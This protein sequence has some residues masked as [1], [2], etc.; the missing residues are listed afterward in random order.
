MVKASRISSW[1]SHELVSEAGE[2]LGARD[3]AAPSQQPDPPLVFEEVHMKFLSVQEENWGDVSAP[4]VPMVPV[5]LLLQQRRSV[6]MR[7]H[8][9]DTNIPGLQITGG[10]EH[11]NMVDWVTH[12]Y[13][14][15]LLR[16]G[17]LQNTWYKMIFL[18]LTFWITADTCFHFCLWWAVSLHVCAWQMYRAKQFG[19][20]AW[21]YS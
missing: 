11:H 10:C 7:A 5:Q 19:Y 21:R 18:L 9:A 20:C 15:W 1:R 2:C 17:G 14:G 8:P 16:Y 13:V 12:I 3:T 6:E 4:A